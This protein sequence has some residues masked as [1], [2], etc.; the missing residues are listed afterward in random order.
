MDFGS[1]ADFLFQSNMDDKF[2]RI[3]ENTGNEYQGKVVV[4]KFKSKRFGKETDYCEIRIENGKNYLIYIDDV[5]RVEIAVDLTKTSTFTDI[6]K[7][8]KAVYG[9]QS[10]KWWIEDTFNDCYI[11]LPRVVIEKISIIRGMEAQADIINDFIS[12]NP[13]C[14]YDEEYIYSK[15]WF[16]I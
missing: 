9:E 4:V 7:C 8:C 13:E 10:D 3:Y 11:E 2:V 15:S 6:S 16:E 12:T 5:Q 1:I 14:L